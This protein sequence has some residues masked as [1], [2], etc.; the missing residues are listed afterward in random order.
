VRNV[1][2][3]VQAG[4]LVLVEPLSGKGRK[5]EA[6]L[7]GLRQIPDV[8]GGLAVMDPKT[9]RIL[10]LVGGWS[11]QQSQ[12]NRTTQAQRQPGSAIKPFVY[13]TALQ[14]GY[15]LSST[16]D[17][18]P[19]EVP[20]GPG[21]PPWRPGNYEGDYYG[22]MTLENALVHS[23]NLATAHLALD[24]GMRAIA[25]TVQAFDI[26]DRMPLYPSMALGAGE[27]TLLRLTNAYAM[28]DNGGHWLVPSVI[29]TVQDRNGGVIYQKGVDGC[30]SCFVLA[31]TRTDGS[32]S[33]LYRATGAPAPSAIA[34]SGAAWAKDPVAY[35]PVK[36]GPLADPIAIHEIVETL[37]QVIQ[38]GTGTLIRPIAKDL[39]QPLA[40]K[41]GT[42]SNYFDA[43]F[44]GFSPDLVAGTYVGFDE[45]RTLGD[46]ETGGRVAAGIFRDFIHEA[47]KGAPEKEFPEP[48][49][50][51]EPGKNEP[52]PGEAAVADQG[53]KPGETVAE[54]PV[55]KRATPRPDGADAETAKLNR[56]QV[57]RDPGDA[58]EEAAYGPRWRDRR[59]P[60][61]S[62]PA[63][64]A[65]TEPA[66]GPP[67]Q[68][69]YVTAGPGFPTPWGTAYAQPG[70][71]GGYD[72]PALPP[73]R[74]APGPRDGRVPY[75]APAPTWSQRPG[76]VYGTGGLY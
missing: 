45:P 66:Y 67:R 13:L 50:E 44:V 3:V 14:H 57:Y 33:Q 37:Q 62:D 61:D 49:K 10:A 71:S 30:A 29:D 35:E 6:R 48:A 34:V 5:A 39:A 20:Q 60:R 51:P 17:D 73:R 2:D 52:S 24:I 74:S 22:E 25:Q 56:Q 28:L 19:L 8:G 43:W 26:M 16:V 36:H 15:T 21:L 46:G 12:F 68:P 63:D 40:G 59:R 53:A 58:V 4:D 65:P 64:G 9:G 47:L 11:F 54:A 75:A 31:G 55:R 69:D 18:T 23:R 72:G 70:P 7:Y 27:T 1:A 41:T 42:T 32:A 38:R 76:P